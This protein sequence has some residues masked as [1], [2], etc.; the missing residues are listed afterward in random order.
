MTIVHFPKKIKPDICYM[1]CKKN[2]FQVLKM[3]HTA[4]LWL[5]QVF[6]II[7][8]WLIHILKKKEKKETKVLAS[9]EFYIWYTY[10]QNNKYHRTWIFFFFLQY[11]EFFAIC[12]FLMFALRTL[13]IITWVWPVTF[14]CL[15]SVHICH[16]L[17]VWTHSK[18]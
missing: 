1:N 12:I 13:E 18:D 9:A 4:V 10:M 5:F 17:S 6:F 14:Q 8:K 15:Y 7:L 16:K 3:A 11:F 2:S